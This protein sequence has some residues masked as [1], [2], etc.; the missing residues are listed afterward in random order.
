MIPLMLMWPHLPMSIASTCRA[1]EL[2]M[3][4]HLLPVYTVNEYCMALACDER[5]DAAHRV[6]VGL[7][8]YSDCMWQLQLQTVGSCT[9]SD[10]RQGQQWFQ[11]WELSMSSTVAAAAAAA[12][13]AAFAA[14]RWQ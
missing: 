9:C 7:C 14:Q 6:A 8:A 10:L 2:S 5:V 12:A 3:H 13:A 4:H 1:V 11:Q